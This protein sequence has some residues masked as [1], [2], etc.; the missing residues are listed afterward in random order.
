[1][2]RKGTRH[3]AGAARITAKAVRSRPAFALPKGL[4]W[5]PLVGALAAAAVLHAR[6]LGAP[7]FADD[8]LF[9]DV[10]RSRSLAGAL[11]AQDP[12][13]NFFRPLGRTL[14]FWI[15]AHTSGESAPVF[16]AANLA[17]FLASVAL[18]WTLVRRVAGAR[19]AAV[20]AA[21]L[22]ITQA[23]DVPVRWASGSQDLLAVTL[24]LAGM[25][26]L[27]RGRRAFAAVLF[28]LA[29]LAKET[30]AFA[31]VPAMILARAPGEPWRATVRRAL[32]AALAVVAWTSVA[33]FAASG[34]GQ[35][36]SPLTLSWS[37]PVAALVNF[38]R[39]CCGV[40]WSTGG[41]PQP[42]F[43]PVTW[44][45][46]L[47]AGACVWLG[48]DAASAAAPARPAR[49]DVALAGVMWAL[50]GAA[51][52]MFVAPIWSAYYYLFAVAGGALLAGLALAAVPP[53]AAVAVV[54]MV[55]GLQ[56]RA[57]DLREFTTQPASFSAQSH[58]NDFYLGRG[59]NVVARAIG[60]LR[61]MRPTVPPRSSFFY[62][63]LPS[64]AGVQAGDGPFVRSVYRDSSL[65]SYYL[66]D[67]DRAK[68]ERG[69]AFFMFYSPELGH[70]QDQSD[71]PD[72]FMRIALGMLLNGR[73]D[74]AREA[75]EIGRRRGKVSSTAHYMAATMALDS[76]DRA[77][78]DARFRAAGCGL[79]AD[80]GEALRLAQAKLAWADTAAAEAA[81]ETAE[82]RAPYDARVHALFT[83][84]L[85]QHPGRQK[86]AAL[87]SY[88]DRVLEPRSGLAWRRWAF[89]LYWNARMEEARKALER[90]FALAP[91]QAA[92]DAD[93]VALRALLPRVTSG[94]DLMQRALENEAAR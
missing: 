24:A 40:E 65:R 92:A 14:W 85:L 36:G 31:F 59:M 62:A 16:H 1:M 50:A 10:V 17:L 25:S 28:F 71:D 57:A 7:F 32:P 13:G 91:Q 66:S 20:A 60:D 11:A 15:L 29:P 86:L 42:P 30:V 35:A 19:A 70:F 48:A 47:L 68:L 45:G 18:L 34:L 73:E 76:G 26:A 54:L 74:A 53:A 94:G 41:A 83:D 33:K 67:L 43:G 2:S 89:S 80:A 12:I 77:A 44:A 69:P 21:L 93:A 72:L 46:L 5:L 56:R 37:S 84:L 55:G 49:R 87:E 22:A 58:V 3:S 38:L 51:P 79:A 6:A 64:F 88:F 61:S 8:W 81:L 90:Y 27:V 63:G 82:V 52:V 9:L 4:A 23:A 75:L 78:A 39:T